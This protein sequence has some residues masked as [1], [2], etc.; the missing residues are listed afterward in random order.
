MTSTIPPVWIAKTAFDKFFA[1][2]D[3]ADGEI[4]GLGEITLR[5]SG[6]YITDIHLIRQT[7]T[8]AETVLN[9]NA[10][11]GFMREMMSKGKDLSLFRLWWHSH[12]V[13]KVGWSK[14][15][16]EVTIRTLSRTKYLVSIV[17]N[18]KHDFATR[19]DI[20]TPS[21]LSVHGFPLNIYHTH[22]EKPVDMGLIREEVAEKVKYE[23]AKYKVVY[24]GKEVRK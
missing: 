14:N 12:G 16:D 6:I 19:Y 24:V 21:L 17:G 8:D 15:K 20:Q 23:K 13:Y 3:V 2:I 18:K 22:G 5:A 9:Q 11:A 4:G 1:Y 10:L 7:T